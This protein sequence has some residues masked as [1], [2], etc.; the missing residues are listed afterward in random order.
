MSDGSR[1]RGGLC[2]QRPRIPPRSPASSVPLSR[3][4]AARGLSKMKSNAWKWTVTCLALGAF[5][6]S[7]AS[8]QKITD[9]RIQELIRTAAERAGVPGQAAGAGAGQQPATRAT[10]PAGTDGRPVVALTLD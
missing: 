5:A 2:R 3:M 7:V 6:P 8:A 9:E 1:T 10:G 4:T